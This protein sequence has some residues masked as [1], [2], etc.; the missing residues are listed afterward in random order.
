MSKSRKNIPRDKRPLLC[1]YWVSQVEAD[2]GKLLL[3]R[4]NLLQFFFCRLYL[5]LEVLRQEIIELSIV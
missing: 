3:L 1:L 4:I 2:R 5:F